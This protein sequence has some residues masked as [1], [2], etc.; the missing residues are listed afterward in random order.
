[1]IISKLQA[2]PH[3]CAFT[4]STRCLHSMHTAVQCWNLTLLVGQDNVLI[5]A[6][7]D[8]L[9]HVKELRCLFT[10]VWSRPRYNAVWAMVPKHCIITSIQCIQYKGIIQIFGDQI[11]KSIPKQ[12]ISEEVNLAGRPVLQSSKETDWLT[13]NRTMNRIYL[14]A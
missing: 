9:N 10:S 13:S 3:I 1:M 2:R 12:H 4:Y 7:T 8:W 11:I 14:V 5:V 6:D